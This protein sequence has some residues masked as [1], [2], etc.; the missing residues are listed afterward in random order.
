[1]KR[2]FGQKQ[3]PPPPPSMDDASDRLGKR[4]DEV[5]VRIRKVDEEL[6]KIKE[7]MK[8]TRSGPARQ[9]LQQ[10]GVQLLK[11]KKMYENHRGQVENQ[12]FNMDQMKFTTE[13][14]KDTADQV[15]VMKH[16]AG[17]LKKETKAFDIGEIEK[18]QDDM[19]DVYDD[20]NEIQEI[21]SRNYAMTEDVDEA[22]LEAELDALEDEMMT[23]ADA[24]YLDEAL[25]APAR[26][27]AKLEDKK[28]EETDPARL[29]QQLGL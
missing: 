24:S 10:R 1:M 21:L 28:E 5:D 20:A 9:R 29:E 26:P 19:Q 14:I 8:K 17:V 2:L 25:A 18:L 13:Q 23:S 16:A 27:A 7:Q 6:I 11:Q 3:A 22:D 4:C 12:R 15:A